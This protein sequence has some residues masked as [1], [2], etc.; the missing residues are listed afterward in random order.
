MDTPAPSEPERPATA[1]ATPSRRSFIRGLGV[2]AAGAAGIG[3]GGVAVYNRLTAL[4][5][6][7]FPPPTASPAQAF[8]H[9]I[10]VMFENRSF[11]NILGWL[12]PPG[13][14]PAGASFDGLHQGTYTNPVPGSTDVIPARPYTGATD[15]IMSSP[16]PDQ[17]GRAHV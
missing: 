2:A 9:L 8:D 1:S 4:P 12:Y 13:E 5:V 11:D 15:L 7:T 17:I 14:V 3:L 16:I 10:V 6:P